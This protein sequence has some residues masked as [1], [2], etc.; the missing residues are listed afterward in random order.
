MIRRDRRRA[1]TLIE[2]LVVIAIIAILIG[3]LLPAVQKVRE[4]AARSTSQNNLKQIGLGSQNYHDTYMKLPGNG[5]TGAATL[6]TPATATSAAFLY[7]ILPYIEQDAVYQ[8]GSTLTTVGAI[9]IFLEPSRARTGTVNNFPVTDYAV[10]YTGL[11]GT[12]TTAPTTPANTLNL[13]T[14]SDGTSNTILAGGKAMAVADYAST[15]NDISFLYLSGAGTSYANVRCVPPAGL[16]TTPTLQRD[17]ATT[18]GLS[19]NWGGPYV[20]G[21]LFAFHDGH[22]STIATSWASTTVTLPDGVTTAN[23]LYTALTPT[24]GETVAFE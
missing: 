22:V 17:T 19:D 14:L 23:Y 1:F 20:S 6:A 10:N 8:T 11:Y 4:A 18:A 7:Q 12:S 15:T 3:L 16:V 21:V 5:L 13:A 24:G 2:L 9:K